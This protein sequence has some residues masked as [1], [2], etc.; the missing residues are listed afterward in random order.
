MTMLSRRSV[1]AIPARLLGAAGAL[2]V[3][4]S[5]ERA[6]R[7][8]GAASSDLIVRSARPQDLET[9]VSLLDSWLTP[10]HRFFVRSHLYTPDVDVRQWRL[11]V[12][13]EVERPLTLTFD[14]LRKL[15]KQSRVVTIECAGNGRAYYDPPVA[16][17]QWRKGAVGTARWTGVRL[18]DVLDRAGVKSTARYVLLSGA[19]VPLAAMPDFVRQVPIE[20]AVHPDT[21]LA[22][23]MNGSPLPAANG[24]PLR[25]IV[26]G[27]EG[28]YAVKW[29]TGIRA[30]D[31][32]GDSFWIQTAYRY[33][34][35]PIA[36]GTPV[37]PADMTP[38]AGLFVKSLI[39]APLDGATVAAGTTLVRG[40][41]WAGEANI[42]GVDI[43][44]DGGS[45]WSPARLRDDRA[46]ADAPGAPARPR[47]SSKSEGGPYAW[48]QFE[49]EWRATGH[50]SHEIMSRA[51]DDRGRVQPAVAQWNPSG[52][53]WNAI[54]RVRVDVAAT[55]SPPPH[56]SHAQAGEGSDDA[57]DAFTRSCLICHDRDLIAQQRLPRAGW[58]REVEKM[59]RWGAPV[60]EP[61]KT[62]L[63]DYLAKHYP[64]R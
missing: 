58:V 62:A 7:P 17:V 29:L 50:G 13:G 6:A 34:K 63:V 37:P 40:F 15:P 8:A 18:A 57:P 39:T 36:P 5:L 4:A 1:L 25:A 56:A 43:S 61:E 23:E 42:T 52:Y 11:T 53:L 21:L 47:R 54:D 24:F 31:R 33:P 14:A 55:Q 2:P 12:D 22:Y 51:V 20:K 59:M 45:T 10:N 48:R 16:G 46:S 35:A 3:L 64:V 41:A 19:D 32:E 49:Y 26:P 28:A 60:S 30:V 38:I 27:W 44:T 9:P